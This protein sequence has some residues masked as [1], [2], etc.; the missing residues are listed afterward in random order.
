MS[1]GTYRNCFDHYQLS[2]ADLTRTM[3]NEPEKIGHLSVANL[4]R[5]ISTT[6]TKEVS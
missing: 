3:S 5:N 6:L 1:T 2:E 4:I